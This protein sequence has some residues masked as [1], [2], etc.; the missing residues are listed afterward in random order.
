MPPPGPMICGAE[1]PTEIAGRLDERFRW[2]ST[3]RW[4]Q[5]EPDETLRGRSEVFATSPSLSSVTL[6]TGLQRAPPILR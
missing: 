3:G 6:T 4:R 1:P 2:L 5:A